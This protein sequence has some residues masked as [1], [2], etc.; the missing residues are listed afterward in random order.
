LLP[1]AATATLPGGREHVETLLKVNAVGTALLF[2]SAI[3]LFAWTV[4]PRAWPV[5]A[6]VAMAIVSSSAEGAYALWRFSRRGVPLAEVRNLNID[7]LSN[8]WPPN[9]LRIDGLPRCFWWVPQHSMAYALGLIA[10]AVTTAAG[11]GAPLAAIVIAGLALA[12]AAMMNPFVGGV[13][14]LVW[15][16]A[17]VVDAARS[18]DVLRRV[19][20]HAVA[21]VP[22][23]CAVVWCVGN[24]MV[25]GAGGALQFGWLGEARNGPVWTLLL[26][27]GPVLVAALIGVLACL[28]PKGGSHID[29]GR[30]ID[31]RGFRLQAE[32]RPAAPLLLAFV[33]L[34]LMYFV[35]LDVDR[36]WVGF[37]A[38]QLF[39]FAAHALI[40]RGLAAAGTWRVVAVA[41]AIAAAAIGL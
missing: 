20:R 21:A 6:G 30:H 26:S 12:G 9:G 25:E 22:V 39:L 2:V 14:S 5:A 31:G 37:R 34:L 28:P 40:A 27:L 35:R 16:L 29:S 23:A 18:G 41:V 19:L 38:G 13:F 7:A 10:L 33:A 4:V 1:A 32:V 15:G 17:V 3:F 11:S 24:Q 8:W 36:A